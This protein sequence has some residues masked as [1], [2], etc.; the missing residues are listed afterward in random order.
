VASRNKKWTQYHRKPAKMKRKDFIKTSS[1]LFAGGA[2][3]P[4]LSCH[5]KNDGDVRK[6][7]AGNYTY[8]ADS[9]YEPSSVEELQQLVKKLDKQKALG[10][11]HCFN[12]IADSPKNQISTRRLNKM[13]N[14]DTS[15]NSVTVQGGVRYGDFA[16]ELDSKGYALQNLAS[17]P[18]ITVT[19]ACTTATHGSGVTLGNLA[20]QV[21]A[22]EIVNP[23]GEIVKID[24]SHPEF[25]GLVVGLGAFGIITNITLEVEKTFQVRQD[26]FQELPLAS[27]EK[28][29]DEI[30]S[31][32]YSVSLFTNWLDQRI[33]QVW[34]K[35][36]TDKA[37]AE[38]TNDF[39]GA[40]AATRNL[41]PIVTMS[42]ENCTDQMG[43]AGPWY[44]R[45][46]HFKMGFVPSGGKELQ[47]EFFVPHGN[48]V[49]AI[50][51]LE[52]KKEL[53]N[54][55]LL[56]SEIRTIAADDLWMSPC[57]H[58]D[59][60][61]IHFTWKQNPDEV[62]KLIP[63]IESELAPYKMKP[64]WGKLFSLDPAVLH[65]RYEKFSDFLALAK[66][67]DPDGKFRNHY[68]DLNIY[69]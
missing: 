5:T 33:S 10:S 14:L 4:G 1:L 6:N 22:M 24:R 15:K 68:L 51:A 46:P 36:R 25:H 26:V 60:V 64:H 17:L 53:I 67:Y 66:K 30:M 56:I 29:F 47:S 65:E 40:K 27:L 52:K 20:T 37:L 55:Q 42:A 11:R 2:L 9:Y 45:L 12:D 63:M 61:A 58:Q 28:H 49:D 35:R 31:S 44:N 39:F 8:K 13:T 48:A 23:Q 57:Y 32:G 16:A 62:S 59:S 50:L 38:L 69:S 41:H 18:H 3:T 54:P 7:W 43:M 21:M 19:G 34:I